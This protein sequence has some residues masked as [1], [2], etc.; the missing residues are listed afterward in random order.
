[1]KKKMQ[2]TEGY[3]VQGCSEGSTWWGG[4]GTQAA[5]RTI[6]PTT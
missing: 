1:M 2:H 4:G 3:N 5:S 6:R